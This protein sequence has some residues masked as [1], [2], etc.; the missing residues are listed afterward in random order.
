MAVAAATTAAAAAAATA[1][2]AAHG[3]ERHHCLERGQQLLA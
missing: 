3:V 2:A 1:A